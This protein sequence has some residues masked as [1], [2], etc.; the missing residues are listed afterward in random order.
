MVLRRA[1]FNRVLPREDRIPIARV[2][3]DRSGSNACCHAASEIE[4][5]REAGGHVAVDQADGGN[6]AADIAGQGQ[7]AGLD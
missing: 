4:M 3:G 1:T 2:S 5:H 7:I 6:A